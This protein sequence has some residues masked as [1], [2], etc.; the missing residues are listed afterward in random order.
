MY[1]CHLT[2]WIIPKKQKEPGVSLPVTVGAPGCGCSNKVC[3]ML[4]TYLLVCT[5]RK[6]LQVLTYHADDAR[7]MEIQQSNT[8]PPSQ[9]VTYLAHSNFLCMDNKLS[10]YLY[11]LQVPLLLRSS[12]ETSI[13]IIRNLSKYV[14]VLSSI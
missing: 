4:C 9:S 14:Q 11:G 2:L 8:P 6:L 7:G 13:T 10:V 1:T 3:C 5:P 12:Y